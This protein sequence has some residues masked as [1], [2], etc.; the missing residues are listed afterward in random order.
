MPYK[1]AIRKN[2]TGEIR[3]YEVEFEWHKP[4]GYTD[5]FWWQEGNFSCDCNRERAWNSQELEGEPYQEYECGDSR[6]SALYAIL[7]NGEEI[8]IDE[9]NKT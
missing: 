6:F 8:L 7:E 3:F 2:E 4:D 5:L 1:V 9:I